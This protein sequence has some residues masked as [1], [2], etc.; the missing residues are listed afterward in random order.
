MAN[1][2][3]VQEEVTRQLIRDYSTTSLREVTSICTLGLAEEAG[4]VAGL[5]KREL[6]NYPQDR[7]RATPEHYTEELG[8][9]LWYLAACCEVFH[10]S[11]EDVW[12][13]NIEKLKKRYDNNAKT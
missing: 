2:K 7:E 5:L 4:E 1:L 13:T 3:E 10:I 11:L 9:V 12:R 6:R 8:D